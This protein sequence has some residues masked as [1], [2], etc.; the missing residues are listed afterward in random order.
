MIQL[1]NSILYSIFSSIADDLI[2]T[3][4]HRP[5][6]YYYLLYA[7][8][9]CG[10]INHDRLSLHTTRETWNK[11]RQNKKI[12]W[13]NAV[14]PPRTHVRTH[15][16]THTHM[17]AHTGTHART[18]ER[19]H[20]QTRGKNS[21]EF[22]PVFGFYNVI[23]YTCWSLCGSTVWCMARTIQHLGNTAVGRAGGKGPNQNLTAGWACQ[24]YL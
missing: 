5:S 7:F 1:Y 3:Q 22:P 17:R 8:A 21:V 18:H 11:Y 12:D 13:C 10:R 15:T 24:I 2:S 20:A 19:T 16:H 9:I 23:Y 14:L 6:T 4:L